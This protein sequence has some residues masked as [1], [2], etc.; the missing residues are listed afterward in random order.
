L[1]GSTEHDQSDDAEDAQLD[2]R[3]GRQHD[4]RNV[5]GVA[6]VAFITYKN[7]SHCT[8]THTYAW[9]TPG[10]P[11]EWKRQ[12]AEAMTRAAEFAM[13]TRQ[14]ELLDDRE[15]DLLLQLVPQ[16]TL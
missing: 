3:D 16:E 11:P 5:G 13:A 9:Q 6:R 1:D 8:D 12:R 10:E 14:A 7:A 2:T 4:G 15:R